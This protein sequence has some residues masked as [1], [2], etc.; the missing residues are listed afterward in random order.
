[1]KAKLDNYRIFY[2]VAQAGSFSKASDKLYISQSAISQ[3]MKQLEEDLGT[4]LFQ[5]YAKGVILTKEGEVLFHYVKDAIDSLYIGEKKLDNMRNLEEGSLIIGA[6]DTIS[7]NYLLPYLES[8]HKYYPN[9]RLQVYNRTSIEMMELVK[10]GRVDVAFVNLPM[11]EKDIEIHPCFVIHDIFIASSNYPMKESYTKKEIAELPLILLERNS[12]SR[13]YV[14][15]QFKKEHINLT[16]QIEIGAHELLLQFAKINLGIACV[17]KEF[18]TAYLERNDVLELPLKNP[19]PPRS[20]GYVI[21]QKVP[22]SSAT[23]LFLSL[24]QKKQ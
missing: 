23:K 22:L 10:A 24:I 17:I 19:L 7:S 9:I 21:N 16:A 11:K 14:D 6:G 1:M 15:Q 8:F 2:E 12:N 20:I 5:R 4:K 3:V 18:S 13:H